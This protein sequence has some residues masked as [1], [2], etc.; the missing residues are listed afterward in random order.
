MLVNGAVSV[1]RV[2]SADPGFALC[3]MLANFVDVI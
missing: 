1:D 3:E 2:M